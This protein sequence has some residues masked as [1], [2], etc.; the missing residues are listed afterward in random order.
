MVVTRSAAAFDALGRAMRR[1]AIERSYVALVHGRPAARAGRIEAPVGRD[2]GRARMTIGG[3]VPRLA[4]THFTVARA[5]AHTRRCSTCDSAPAARTRSACTSRRSGTRWSATRSTARA[6][7]ERYGLTR[8]FL[9]AGRLA[10]DHPL[11]GEPLVFESP[12]PPDLER[13]LTRARTA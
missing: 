10:F 1:R 13:A 11:T 12:L 3:T 5:A 4:V 6:S 9:H 2:R 7:A 8:Q